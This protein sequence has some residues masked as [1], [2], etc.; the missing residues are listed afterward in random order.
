MCWIYQWTRLIPLPNVKRTT[1]L[2]QA[3]ISWL[4]DDEGVVHP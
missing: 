2:N 3:N 1:L 4:L